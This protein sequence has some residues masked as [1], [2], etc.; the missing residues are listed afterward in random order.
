M[1]IC[2][3]SGCF[4]DSIALPQD[5]SAGLMLA[6][7]LDV[8]LAVKPS[9]KENRCDQGHIGQSTITAGLLFCNFF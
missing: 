8:D 5:G 6:D 4:C 3:L 1:P 9:I 7:L 2:V